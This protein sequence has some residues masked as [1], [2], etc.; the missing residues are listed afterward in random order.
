[1]VSFVCCCLYFWF[2]GFDFSECPVKI[3]FWE[4][5]LLESS[6]FLDVEISIIIH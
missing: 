6:V 5:T 1:M 3:Y 4:I 2:C